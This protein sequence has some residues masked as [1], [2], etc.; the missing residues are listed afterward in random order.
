M[1]SIQNFVVL[2][3]LLMVVLGV[4]NEAGCFKKEPTPERKTKSTE[5]PTA[6]SRAQDYID[7][8]EKREE[9]ILLDTIITHFG[10]RPGY[11]EHDTVY[12]LSYQTK[13]VLE[14]NKLKQTLQKTNAKH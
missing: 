8:L 11:L 4:C 9:V 13:N 10:H 3:G 6:F 14:A 5:S 12:K 1:K 7:S 2:V